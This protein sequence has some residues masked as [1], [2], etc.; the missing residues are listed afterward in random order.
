[1]PH[2]GISIN[3]GILMARNITAASIPMWISGVPHANLY[4]T[5]VHTKYVDADVYG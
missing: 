2:I 4:H 5:L 3:A 1:M